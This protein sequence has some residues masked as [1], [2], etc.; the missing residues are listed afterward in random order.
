MA[1]NYKVR[2]GY[3]ITIASRACISSTLGSKEQLL[4]SQIKPL[5]QNTSELLLPGM[6]I[7]QALKEKL[8]PR[9]ATSRVASPEPS[10]SAHDCTVRMRFFFASQLGSHHSAGPHGTWQVCRHTAQTR[11]THRVG[12][13]RCARCIRDAR[14]TRRDVPTED[15]NGWGRVRV[16]GLERKARGGGG[17]VVER[18]GFWSARA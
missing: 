15:V 2:V 8:S 9:P 17:A 6:H 12:R 4:Y 1:R 14:G 7:R 10:I 16:R 3:V 13:R 5:I 18:Y 11:A